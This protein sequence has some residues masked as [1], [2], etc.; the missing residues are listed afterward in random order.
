VRF[1][2]TGDIYDVTDIS[3]RSDCD[4]V[5]IKVQRKTGWMNSALTAT[6]PKQ[7]AMKR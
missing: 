3:R 1:E 2:T 4:F 7:I 5:S 6:K